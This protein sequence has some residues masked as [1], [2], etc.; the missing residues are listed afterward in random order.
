MQDASLRAQAGPTPDRTAPGAR[1]WRAAVAA[2]TRDIR[3][4]RL[5]QAGLVL[6]ALANI[7]DAV[8]ISM[9]PAVSVA[10]A[11]FDPFVRGFATSLGV[12]A[13]VAIT[14][15]AAVALLVAGVPMSLGGRSRIDPV[16]FWRA[17]LVA[18]I[19]VALAGTA[20][21]IVNGLAN[22]AAM[23]P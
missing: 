4:H 6:F 8:T 3:G 23:R 10:K 17:C 1:G 19:A 11:E 15:L 2:I 5:A 22:P 21:N 16:G 9:V 7:A 14:K 13:A 20:L 18:G 12:P